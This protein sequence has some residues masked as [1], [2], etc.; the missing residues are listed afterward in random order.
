[1]TTNHPQPV[2]LAQRAF[3]TETITAEHHPYERGMNYV[4]YVNG[5]KSH[6]IE[7]H[8]ST[9]ASLLSLFADVLRYR[10]AYATHPFLAV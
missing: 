9:E 5:G 6:G 8:C 10:L 7:I 2:L 3:A 4:L 1:M